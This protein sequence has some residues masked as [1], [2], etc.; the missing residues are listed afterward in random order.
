VAAAR[1][2]ADAD[3]TERGVRTHVE[4]G[5]RAVAA[6]VACDA[7]GSASPRAE[8]VRK[9]APSLSARGAGGRASG[10]GA[11]FRTFF[12]HSRSLRPPLGRPL[13]VPRERRLWGPGEVLGVVGRAHEGR[14]LFATDDDRRFFV[15]R[16]RKVFVA[17][18]VELLAWALLINHY[19]LLIRVGD[20][21]PGRVFLRFN[22]VLAQRERRRRGDHGAVFQDRFWSRPCDGDLLHLLTYVLGNPVHHRVLPS[23]EALETYPWTAYPEVLGLAKPGLVD[24]AATLRLVHPDPRV[25]VPTLREAMAARIAG[26][27]GQRAGVD[28]CDDPVCRRAADGCL[29]V[30]HERRSSPGLEQAPESASVSRRGISTEHDRRRE[31]RLALIASG[32]GLRDVVA[33]TAAHLGADADAVERGVR[34]HV[35]S[36]ARAVAAY[37]ACDAL[38]CP[39]GEVAALLGVSGTA[40]PRARRRGR[41]ILEARGWTTDDVV[42]SLTTSA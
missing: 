6:Y 42:G 38:G 30:H 36:G 35:E 8:K 25:A 24:A 21:A 7:L 27:H 16:L 23:A 3:A 14:P 19:H 40:L 2:G 22:T 34:T 39:V 4:S 31:R 28:V 32:R 9:S 33:M 12:A 10:D 1:R 5:A 26:W 11:D 15:E 20:V 41:A 37:V 18:A 29:L 17:P 13:G